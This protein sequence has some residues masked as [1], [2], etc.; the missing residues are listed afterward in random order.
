MNSIKITD[1]IIITL[2]YVRSKKHE[3]FGSESGAS[4]VITI[5]AGISITLLIAYV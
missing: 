2:N 1:S 4:N 3:F 5:F